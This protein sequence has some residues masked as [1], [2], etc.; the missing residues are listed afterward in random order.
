M[1]EKRGEMRKIAIT[2]RKGGVG[3]TTTAVNLAPGLALEVRPDLYILTGSRSFVGQKDLK[4]TPFSTE[5]VDP[6]ESPDCASYKWF[7]C[8]IRLPREIGS[9]PFSQWTM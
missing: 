8:I 5:G 6:R 2:N 4:D 7:S 9:L 3:K 1:F